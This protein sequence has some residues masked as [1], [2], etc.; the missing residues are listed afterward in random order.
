VRV[1]PRL[2]C[3]ILSG[4]PNPQAAVGFLLG[5]Q[6]KTAMTENRLDVETLVL[7]GTITAVPSQIRALVD[8]GE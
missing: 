4:A 2:F 8:Q 5:A 6:A 3:F 7:A 1:H